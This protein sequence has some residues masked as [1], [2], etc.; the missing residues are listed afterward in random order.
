MNRKD[1]EGH[2]RCEDCQKKMEWRS[3]EWTL[4]DGRLHCSSCTIRDLKKGISR[5]GRSVAAFR[6]PERL[7]QVKGKRG[8]TLNGV[9]RL[10]AVQ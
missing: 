10:R 2:C 6:F 4:L 8:G 1:F 3:T 7:K 5:H 9:R